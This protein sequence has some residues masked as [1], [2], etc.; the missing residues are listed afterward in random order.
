MLP[1]WLPPRRA[2]LGAKGPAPTAP[3]V[4][5]EAAPLEKEQFTTSKERVLYKPPPAAFPP[6]APRPA[7]KL[8]A[9]PSPP[10]PPRARLLK[11][12]ELVIDAGPALQTPPP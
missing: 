4:P 1:P 9:P 11:N 10:V 5:P 8:P 7:L 6:P 3:L 12:V 2:A